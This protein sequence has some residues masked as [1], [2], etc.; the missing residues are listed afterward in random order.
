MIVATAWPTALPNVCSSDACERLR[1]YTT[2]E[3]ACGILLGNKKGNTLISWTM[4]LNRLQLHHGM[5]AS[6]EGYLLGYNK[7]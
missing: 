6:I 3:G 7:G 2:G 4:R 1:H 5:G